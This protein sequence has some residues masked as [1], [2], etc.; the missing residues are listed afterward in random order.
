M[1]IIGLL[2]TATV[3][4]TGIALLGLAFATQPDMRMPIAVMCGI[5]IV[6]G[7]GA[8]IVLHS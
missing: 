2:M 7:M 1:K 8:L 3:P 4:A 5:M 6:G